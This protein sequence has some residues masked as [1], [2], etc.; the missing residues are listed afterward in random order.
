MATSNLKIADLHCDLL[1]YIVEEKGTA[2][3]PQSKCSWPQLKAG[4]VSLQTVA[5]YVSTNKD[6]V[7][8]F[9]SQVDAFMNLPTLYPDHFAHLKQFKVPKGE[10]KVHLLP[11]IENG[12]GLV[13]EEEPLELAFRRLDEFIDLSPSP[14]LYI[15]LTWKH[16]NRFGGGNESK[17]GIKR[18]GELFLEYLS[19]KNIAIDL[20][21][22]SDALAEGI[23]NTID[24]KGLDLMPIASHS[25]FREVCNH[26]RNLP[27]SFAKEIVARGGVIGLNFVKR[28]IGKESDFLAHLNHAKKLGIF[29]HFCF[30]ADFFCE[31]QFIQLLPSFIPVYYKAFSDASCYPRLLQTLDLTKEEEEQLS[32]RNLEAFFERRK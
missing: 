32:F 15:S 28:F 10:E 12:S 31:S 25:N 7:Q 14:I 17:E 18:D 5:L 11:A 21:H 16:K 26:P 27:D 8:F 24:K 29:D 20:S 3:D 23:F 1:S 22:T 9:Q 13:T 4:G 19:G 6:S 30:G 2:A